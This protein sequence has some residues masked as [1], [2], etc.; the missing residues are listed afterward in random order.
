MLY[1]G[2]KLA[3]R[4]YM[5]KYF[6]KL[7]RTNECQIEFGRLLDLNLVG[8][9]VSVALAMIHDHIDKIFNEKELKMASEKQI[10]L[11]KKFNC[12]FSKLTFDVAFAY[13]QDIMV[14]LNL[15]SIEEQN[16]KSGDYVINK[17]SKKEYIVSSIGNRGD[18]FFKK[19]RGESGGAA[20]YLIKINKEKIKEIFKKLEIEYH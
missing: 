5:E 7:I 18:V 11:G 3:R 9:T 19:G 14:M 8:L 20:R 10:E 15:K 17:Y 6:D 16:I 12:D 13:I 1:L 2:Y 4:S